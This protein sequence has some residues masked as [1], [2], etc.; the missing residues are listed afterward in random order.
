MKNTFLVAGFTIKDILR[1][2]FF[3]ISTLIVILIIFIVL[4]ITSNILNEYTAG[5]KIED[6]EVEQE[7]LAKNYREYYLLYDKNYIFGN[8]L[9]EFMQDVKNEIIEQID[10]D[11]AIDKTNLI[12]KTA[13]KYLVYNIDEEK[14]DKEIEDAIKESNKFTGAIII[15]KTEK[16]LNFNL[17]LHQSNST[18]AEPIELYEDLTNLY[19]QLQINKLD[20][21]EEEKASISIAYSSE[22]SYK[23]EATFIDKR[24]ILIL[25]V[26][27]MFYMG[28]SYFSYQ[29]STSITLEKT[30]K[31]QE[32]L[33]TSSTPMSIVLGKTIGIGFLG[34]VYTGIMSVIIY[35]VA[36]YVYL[37]DLLNYVFDG[38]SINGLQITVMLTFLLLGYTFY[39][40]L[41]ALVGATVSKPEDIRITN[42]PLSIILLISFYI[43]VISLSD[44]SSNLSY[45]VSLIPLSAPFSMPYRYVLGEL[46]KAGIA[47]VWISIA[48][49]I[50][51]IIVVAFLA[52]KMYKLTV[53]NNGSRVTIKDLFK[54]FRG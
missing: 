44:T 4:G 54:L 29:V 52:I 42:M 8:Q 6:L 11:K 31:L 47:S 45:I 53:I 34:L 3:W 38:V 28:I 51:S 26:A 41:Y 24:T 17:K 46:G 20:L 23:E 19:K 43:G 50:V 33:I 48:I 40:F 5:N 9:N 21:T 13:S 12:S 16:G 7:K 22:V 18:N 49:L 1:R 30:S 2:K 35:L 15:T 10:N 14:T 36:K 39:A 37:G 25:L 32:N 27:L